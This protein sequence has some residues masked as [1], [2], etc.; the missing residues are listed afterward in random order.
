MENMQ[1][2]HLLPT[3]LLFIYEFSYADSLNGE[4]YLVN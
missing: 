1:G 4:D 3:P 2:K